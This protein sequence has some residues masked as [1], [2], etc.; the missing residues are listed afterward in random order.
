M[1]GSF[2]DRGG[3]WVLGQFTLMIAALAAG[4]LW[5]GQGPIVLT[6]AG[7]ALIGLGA[8]AGIAGT[9][10]LGRN[11]TAYPKPKTEAQLIRHGIYGR[12]RHPLYTSLML[13]G[14]GWGL[15]WASPAALA[16]SF[17]LALLLHFK[18]AFEERE[19]LRLFPGYAKYREQVPRFFPRV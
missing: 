8:W 16:F 1:N 6:V 17:A 10:T 4:P 5:S 19:L 15:C 13:L 12:I 14:I 11:R 18:A 7:S 3:W 2:T 9:I